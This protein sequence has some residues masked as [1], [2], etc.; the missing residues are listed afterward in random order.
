MSVAATTPAPPQPANGIKPPRPL[1]PNA[2][3][4]YTIGLYLA[5]ALF[6]VAVCG[7]MIVAGASRESYWKVDD[8]IGGG[9]REGRRKKRLRFFQ[10]PS[11]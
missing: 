1:S 4:A 8:E 9:E 5:M 7:L 6:A 10:L 3:I 2:K 11:Y